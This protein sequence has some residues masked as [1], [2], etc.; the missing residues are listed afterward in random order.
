LD[1]FNVQGFSEF[2]KL[3]SD[4]RESRARTFGINGI[5]DGLYGF[6]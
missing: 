3:F 1:L 4:W 2:A 5:D 6:Q